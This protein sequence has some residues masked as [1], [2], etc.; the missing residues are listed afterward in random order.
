MRWLCRLGRIIVVK[1]LLTLRDASVLLGMIRMVLLHSA[2]LVV[3]PQAR[4]VEIF[5]AFVGHRTPQV[6]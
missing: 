4:V 6:S 3:L 2:L 5:R 1:L